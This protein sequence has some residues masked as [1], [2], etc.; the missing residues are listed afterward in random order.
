MS[1]DAGMTLKLVS[2]RGPMAVLDALLTSRW[3]PRQDGWWCVS[4]GE[5]TSSWTC[6]KSFSI[7]SIRSLLTA[8]TGADEVFG[9]RLW[10]D[11]GEVGGEFL[12]FSNCNLL[13]SPSINRVT[14]EHR[15]SDVSWYLP[16]LLGVFEGVGVRVESWEWRESS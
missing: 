3:A 16:R 11:A 9:I 10:W 4:L 1:V 5:D 6:E 12:I 14:L 7:Q 2:P 8:K 15:L 13:F